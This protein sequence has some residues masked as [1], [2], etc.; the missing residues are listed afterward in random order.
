MVKTP[1]DRR[2]E[3]F[4]DYIVVEP[5]HEAMWLNTLSLLEH[6]GSSKIKRAVGDRHDRA[7]VL[8]H[9][10]DE[11]RHALVLKRQALAISPQEDSYLAREAAQTYFSR[12]DHES[13]AWLDEKLG[14]EDTW[15]AY[16]VT[17]ALI[18]QRALRFYPLYQE[19]T[20]RPQ[21]QKELKR[22]IGEETKHRL[23]IEQAAKDAIS[24]IPD[25]WE[26]LLEREDELFGAFIS[27]A[28]KSV[29]MDGDARK[30]PTSVAISG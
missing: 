9:A 4:L 6:I 8:D 24:T 2:T 12:L 22:L 1:T 30:I 15:R 14:A 3:R 26:Y 28:S 20:Q 29:G 23:M 17:T 25:G 5:K 19:K 10:A 16:L 27:E 18:E 7:D 13:N 21:L 11:A